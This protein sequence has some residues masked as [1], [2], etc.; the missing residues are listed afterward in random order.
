MVVRLY[1][2]QRGPTMTQELEATSGCKD[3]VRDRPLFSSGRLLSDD[4]NHDDDDTFA[5]CS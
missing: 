3:T 1:A 2:Q 4:N 5:K